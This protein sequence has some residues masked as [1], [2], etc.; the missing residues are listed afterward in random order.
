MTMSFKIKRAALD[1]LRTISRYT[2]KK[3]GREKE[4]VY[5]KG[6]FACFDAI[7]N[8][9]T[10]NRDLSHLVTGCHSYKI[11]HHLIIFRWLEDG[12]P[13]ILRVLHE[14]MDITLHLVR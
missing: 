11:S 2:R 3:W 12:R 10:H 5:I 1:D 13:E 6:L 14:K 8:H 9:E 4:V 7:A